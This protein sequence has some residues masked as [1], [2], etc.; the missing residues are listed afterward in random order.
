MTHDKGKGGKGVLH[1]NAPAEV[2]VE[3][4]LHPLTLKKLIQLSIDK[5]EKEQLYPDDIL[6]E[7]KAYKAMLNITDILVTYSCIREVILQ[8]Q[9]DA[10]QF[11]RL[12]YNCVTKEHCFF[13]DLSR[14]C[15]LLLG[16][17]LANHVLAHL[18]KSSYEGDIIKQKAEKINFSEKDNACIG[19]LG[20]YVFGTFYR[21]IRNS[22]KWQTTKSQQCLALLL[23]GKCSPK[24]AETET[25]AEKLVNAKNRGGLWTVTAE[26]LKIFTIAEIN[27]CESASTVVFQIDC[28]K[29]VNQLLQESEVISNFTCICNKAAQQVEK[30]VALDMLESLLTL[31]IRV[32]AHSYA[33]NIKERHMV[34]TK[35]QKTRSLRTEIKKKSSSQ[36]QVQG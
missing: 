23:A 29:I 16:F 2:K 17:E 20:G 3:S 12:F 22:K 10:E 11:Y 19:Y 14:N 27:F 34:A 36:E 6:A 9:G 32:R 33:K 25:S 31:Y 1:P 13:K 15:C 35:K 4:I 21:R 18:N 24:S 7:I 26:V 5:F 8:F 30:E 28:P